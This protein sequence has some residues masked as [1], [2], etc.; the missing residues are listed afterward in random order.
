MSCDIVHVASLSAYGGRRHALAR[1]FSRLSIAILPEDYGF[2]L[3]TNRD[4]LISTHVDLSSTCVAYMI[5]V[6]SSKDYVPR[7]RHIST[8]LC[9]LH[10]RG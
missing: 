4:R 6:R 7:Y 1:D 8:A 9:F 2:I 3:R 5:T 10:R